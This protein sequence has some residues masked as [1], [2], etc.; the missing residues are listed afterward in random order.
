MRLFYGNF[1]FYNL[2]CEGGSHGKFYLSC[3]VVATNKWVTGTRCVK[4]GTAI[5]HNKHFFI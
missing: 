4:Y 3:G 2:K 1:S 5:D